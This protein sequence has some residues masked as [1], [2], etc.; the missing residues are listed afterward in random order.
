MMRTGRDF[1]RIG[2]IVNIRTQLPTQRLTLLQYDANANPDPA[3]R[4]LGRAVVGSRPSRPTARGGEPP[5]SVEFQYGFRRFRRPTPGSSQPSE[6]DFE[7]SHL[8]HRAGRADP[9]PDETYDLPTERPKSRAAYHWD[10][11]AR[12]PQSTGKRPTPRTNPLGSAPPPGRKSVGARA[13]AARHTGTLP[14]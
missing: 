9:R 2:D 8:R 1:S 11:T 3:S 10:G 12:L 4:R 6:V 5:I 7:P 14:V 13:R